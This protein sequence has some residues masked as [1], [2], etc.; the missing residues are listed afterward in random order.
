MNNTLGDVSDAFGTSE[1]RHHESL[2][3]AR[4]AARLVNSFNSFIKL[5]QNTGLAPKEARKLHGEVENAVRSKDIFM[6]TAKKALKN[7]PNSSINI[8]GFAIRANYN[9]I[10]TMLDSIQNIVTEMKEGQWQEVLAGNFK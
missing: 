5:L 4:V 2:E 6:H 9:M 7:N 10:S 8:E 1:E 3:E